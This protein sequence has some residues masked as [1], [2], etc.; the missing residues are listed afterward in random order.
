MKRQQQRRTS[1]GAV[2][3]G[4][5]AAIILALLYFGWSEL[6]IGRPGTSGDRDD[7]SEAPVG[8]ESSDPQSTQV[9]RVRVESNGSVRLAGRSVTSDEVIAGC[10]EAGEVVL[11]VAGDAPYGAVADLRA[12]LESAGLT[13]RD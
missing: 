2:A 13:V 8:V 10:R 11:D 4:G 9:C 12:A 1:K 6:G 3:V 5:L 7:G